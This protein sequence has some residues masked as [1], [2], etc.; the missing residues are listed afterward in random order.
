MSSIPAGLVPDS[1]R[2]A[3]AGRPAAAGVDGDAWLAR[4]PGVVSGALEAWGLRVDG[5]SRHGADALVVPVVRDDGTP[6]A[7]KVAWPRPEAAH[8]HLALRAWGGRGAVRLLAADPAERTLLLERLDA[9]TDLGGIWDVEACE[10]I[11]G[12]LAALDRPALPRLDRLSDRARGWRDRLA[13]PGPGL[14]RR[15]VEQARAHVRDLCSGDVDGRLVHTDLHFGK[16]LAR[17]G[18]GG[19]EWAAIGPDP[20]AAEPAVAV[21]PVLRHRLEE[22]GDDVPGLAWTLCARLAAVCDAAGIDE[23]RARAWAIV[24]TVLDALD[25]VETR[26][27][28]DEMRHIALL[29]AL[30][31]GA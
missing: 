12:L 7:L 17:P 26:G 13:R 22:A 11:G 5:P 4:L 15:F 29:K 9:D 28:V 21:W 18:E 8:E 20:L 23:E 16:V 27:A 3:V 24:R 1:F 30:Q 6:A 14:P 10:V 31:R 2:R 25:A 19:D